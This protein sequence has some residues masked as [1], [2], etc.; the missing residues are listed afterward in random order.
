LWRAAP[1]QSD[2]AAAALALLRKDVRLLAEVDRERLGAFLRERAYEA[3][4]E[5]GAGTTA[6]RLARALDY[7]NWHRF[8]VQ[9]RAPDGT[10]RVLTK[11]LFATGS[12]GS[13]AVLVHLPLFAA[14]AAHYA[15]GSAH[16]PRLVLLDEA[17]AGIDRGQ[18]GRCM[19][20]LVAFDL[21][22]LLTSY[23]EWGCY[24]EV[25]G[26]AIYDLARD[27]SSPGVAAMRFV[28]DGNVRAAAE[29]PPAPIVASELP[30]IGGLFDD[31]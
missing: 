18:R 13:K 30:S 16:A 11:K 24:A 8:S 29:P 7:R 1:S 26:V 31:A 21:D 19:A 27:P 20:L 17:F 4:R 6:E 10:A 3:R 25:P 12:G 23:D 22:C 15:S 5:D 2:E 28:W 9:L 14:A